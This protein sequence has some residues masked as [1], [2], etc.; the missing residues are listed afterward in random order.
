MVLMK[1]TGQDLHTL[2]KWVRVVGKQGFRS[3]WFAFLSCSLSNRVTSGC[4]LSLVFL[5]CKLGV[6]MW[7]SVSSTGIIAQLMGGQP[8]VFSSQ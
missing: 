7:P 8:H 1:C 6:I 5:I 4:L 2:T 3:H